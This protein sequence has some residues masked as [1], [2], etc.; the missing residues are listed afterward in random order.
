MQT[1]HYKI[2]GYTRVW[3]GD[4][5]TPDSGHHTGEV[6]SATLGHDGRTVS[7][8]V[9]GLKPGH[10]YDLSV[11]EIGTG[12]NRTLWPAMGHYTLHRIPKRGVATNGQ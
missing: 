12:D 2:S 7:L 11:G 4:Y 5:A 8:V 10:V 3:K 1:S 6:T 9:A